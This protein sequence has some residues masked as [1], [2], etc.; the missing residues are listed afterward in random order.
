MGIDEFAWYSDNRFAAVEMARSASGESCAILPSTITFFSLE[1]RLFLPVR[2]GFAES[3]P[4]N[5]LHT[6][7]PLLTP[8]GAATLRALRCRD[9][10]RTRTNPEAPLAF[11]V[12]AKD[13]ILMLIPY[14][15]PPPTKR[16]VDVAA[17][18]PQLPT[19]SWKARP[20]TNVRKA[21]VLVGQPKSCLRLPT[22]SSGFPPI[23]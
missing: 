6:P 11:E 15:L 17:P 19:A 20:P 10:L 14:C 21:V 8:A 4:T 18:T 7:A 9:P 12:H 3:V 1:F 22:R 16:I 5:L 13:P 2:S 23:F